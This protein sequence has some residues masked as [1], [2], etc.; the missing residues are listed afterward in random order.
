MRAIRKDRD[1]RY[2]SLEDVQFDVAPIRLDLQR[3]RAEHLMIAA[4]EKLRKGCHRRPAA[5]PRNP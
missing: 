2:Q 5:Y 1:L 4:E 3:E